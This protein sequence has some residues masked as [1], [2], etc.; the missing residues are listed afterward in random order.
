MPKATKRRAEREAQKRGFVLWEPSFDRRT[1]NGYATIDAVGN[2]QIDWECR[3]QCVSGYYQTASEFWQD[4]I[5]AMVSLE[6]P[7]GICR[8]PECEFH[9][10]QGEST[11]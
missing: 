8:D 5:D 1:L 10:P 9:N 4:V 7:R 6:R 3:G 2:R 11:W